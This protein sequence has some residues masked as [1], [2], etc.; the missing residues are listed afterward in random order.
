MSS[1][2]FIDR[3]LAIVV[4]LDCPVQ[5][6]QGIGL[7]VVDRRVPARGDGSDDIFL[8]SVAFAGG[9]LLDRAD[10]HALVRDLVVL[11]PCGEVGHE[12][13][14]GVC[15]IDPGV[16]AHLLEVH[17]VDA[18]AGL[19]DLGEP[20]FESQVAHAA[21]LEALRLVGFRS[22]GHCAIAV[23]QCPA[24]LGAEIQCQDRRHGWPPMI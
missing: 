23:A 12:A 1:R 18:V 2:F 3:P 9:V 13:A 4:M 20:A 22:A 14:V 15:R 17:G 8:P 5:Q 24:C 10:R 21:T 11:A 7:V 16:A 19:L 6:C